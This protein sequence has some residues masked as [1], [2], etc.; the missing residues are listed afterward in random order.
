MSTNEEVNIRKART[1]ELANFALE[2]FDRKGVAK[3]EEWI[4]TLDSERDE[5]DRINGSDSPS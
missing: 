3:G 1:E 2:V 5:L 4:R